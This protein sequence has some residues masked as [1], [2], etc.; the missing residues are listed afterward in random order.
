MAELSLVCV[1]GCAWK[2]EKK[3]EERKETS[4][5]TIITFTSSVVSAKEMPFSSFCFPPFPCQP[6]TSVSHLISSRC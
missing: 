3:S 6:P 5:Y 4:I 1:C 2:G